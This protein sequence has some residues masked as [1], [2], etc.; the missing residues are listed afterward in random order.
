MI[1]TKDYQAIYNSLNSTFK[2]NNYKN[3]SS[4]KSYIKKNFYNLNSIEIK[5][6]DD[7]TYDYCI[8][9]CKITNL[10]N[11]NETKE[12]NIIINIGEG[13]DFEMSFSMA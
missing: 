5:E 11:T 13:T 1:N 4:L 10:E 7:K 3:V 6:Y 2:N 8:F 12:V 9:K